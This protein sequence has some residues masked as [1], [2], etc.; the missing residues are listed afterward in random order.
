M[1]HLSLIAAVASNGVIGRANQLPWRLPEDLA[2]LKRVTLGHCVIMGRK[3]FESIGRPLP[4]RRNL[5]VT[6]NPQWQATG[7]EATGS[8]V[9]ALARCPDEEEVFVLG[10][11]RLFRESLALAQRLYIT[12]LDRDYPGD[13]FFPAIPP[14]FIELR[15]ETHRAAADPD[16][17][18][19]FV[20]YERREPE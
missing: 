20:T 8:L 4:Q 14:Q 16:L 7:V 17:Q 6:A 15:R 5:V 19:H 11:E 2:Y 3:T 10:G 9:E 1:A 12:H 13:T 18:F